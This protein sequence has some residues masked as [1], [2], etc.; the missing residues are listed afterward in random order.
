[1][2]SAALQDAV[3]RQITHEFAA[4]YLYLAMS[5]WCETR[6]LR[7]FAHWFRVQSEE[8]R[9]HGLKLFDIV[10]ARGGQVALSPIE[11]PVAAYESPLDVMQ[12]AL[13]HEQ[14]VTAMFQEIY[15]LAVKDNDFTTQT[16]L[17]W[18]LTEQVEEEQIT[19]TI[20]DQLKLIGSQGAALYLL[21]RELAARAATPA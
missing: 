18:F 4:S 20:V 21:D 8:E 12:R 3:N 6:N 15:E 1:M 16:Q 7:G 10:L 2:L 11:A 17:Q 5:A 19:G 9:T 14:A 13:A